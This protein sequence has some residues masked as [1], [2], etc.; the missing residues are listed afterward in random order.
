MSLYGHPITVNI[1]L[2]KC[3]AEA[4][5][6]L[7]AAIAEHRKHTAS[8]ASCACSPSTCDDADDLL[9]KQFVMA[10]LRIYL[11]PSVAAAHAA[12][13]VSAKWNSP[14]PGL[15]TDG[16]ANRRCPGSPA[17]AL[18]RTLL[19]VD[20]LGDLHAEQRVETDALRRLLAKFETI[21]A[22]GAALVS[23]AKIPDDSQVA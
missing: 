15:A 3:A 23:A 9:A 13:L 19:A 1:T 8:C 20:G 12:T 17:D 7:H 18:A 14:Q 11:D 5:D 16:P 21:A 6:A 2:P 10:A 4:D 22:E